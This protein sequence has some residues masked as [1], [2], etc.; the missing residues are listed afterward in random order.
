[1]RASYPLELNTCF[2][3][4]KNLLNGFKLETNEKEEAR[5]IKDNEEELSGGEQL[6]GPCQL[7]GTVSSH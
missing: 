7:T 1:M 4:L 2:L 6:P 5:L 3:Q